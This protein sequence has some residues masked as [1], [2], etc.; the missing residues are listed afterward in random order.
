MLT[1]Y[2]K[3]HVGVSHFCEYQLK[4]TS[5]IKVHK[6]TKHKRKFFA[7]DKCEFNTPRAGYLNVHK[8]SKHEAQHRSYLRN[9]QRDAE[10]EEK[11]DK[12]DLVGLD[13]T[14]EVDDDHT[15]EED[16]FCDTITFLEILFSHF[17][18]QYFYMTSKTGLKSENKFTRQMGSF[19]VLKEAHGCTV[20]ASWLVP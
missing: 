15:G 3:I 7:C 18:S 5:D 1:H 17:S 10:L 11:D 14:P 13:D 9:H 4:W 19:R 8:Q 16:T 6:Q 20:L 12:N 2:K